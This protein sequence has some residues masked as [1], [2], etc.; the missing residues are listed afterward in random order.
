ML[1]TNKLLILLTVSILAFSV[2]ISSCCTS[3]KNKQKETESELKQNN[4]SLSVIRDTSY[5]APETLNYEILSTEITENIL[6]VE[7]SYLGGC[8]THT[9]Q[10]MWTGVYMKSMPMKV[11]LTI[12]HEAIN[13]TCDK[14][15]TE[16]L[17]FDLSP[18]NPGRGDKLVLIIKGLEDKIEW[19]MGND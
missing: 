14:Q 10:L 6:K 15:I 18:L 2:V 7:V 13:E 1:K 16:T 11:P 5:R 9:W 19:I 12:Q 8:G 3:K 17:F 4:T